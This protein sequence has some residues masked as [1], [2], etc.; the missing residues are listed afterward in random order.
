MGTHTVEKIGGTSMS[1]FDDVYDKVIAHGRSGKDLYQRIFVVSAYGGITDLLLEHKKTRKPGVYSLFTDTEQSWA[2]GDAI[3]KVCEKMC[4]VNA[5]MFEDDLDRQTADSFV[6]ERIEGVRSCL[7]DLQRLC[8]FGHFQLDEHLQTVREMLSALGEAHSAHN[9]T[10]LIKNRGINARFIDLTGWR[11]NEHYQLDE[12]IDRYLNDVDFSK[13]LPIVTGYAQCTEG[14][15]HTYDRGY[16]E[17]TFSR[18]AV[19]TE[20]REAVIH[21][22]YH[23]SSADP[24]LVGVDNAQVIGRTNYDVADQLSALGMEAIH[25]RAAK[26]LRQ[27]QIPLRVRNTFEPDHPGT[28][29][30]GDWRA[31]EPRVEIVAGQPH[32]VGIEVHDQDMVGGLGYDQRCLEVLERQK[33]RYVGKDT[34]A[35]TITH[36]LS[37]SLNRIQKLAD[38]MQRE[39][40]QAEI[41]LRKVALVAAIG[42]NLDVPGLMATAVH[43]LASRGINIL[44]M[45]QNM[46]QVDIQFVLAEEDYEEAVVAL[47]RALVES[48]P[49]AGDTASETVEETANAQ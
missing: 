26:G 34:N 5:E 2:W 3:S 48:G 1:R 45:H 19:I 47:H 22:E 44:G 31:E 6:R 20:A 33:L 4:A 25:P 14:L 23:L 30:T 7:I 11:E 21:K 32:L 16:T 38:A 39:F 42:S 9:M 27:S 40:P 29:I 24:R 36:Y 12:K 15:M 35:N 17:I 43:A 10:L 18:I 28:L 13:E 37:A 49:G 41:T 8:S 46:R